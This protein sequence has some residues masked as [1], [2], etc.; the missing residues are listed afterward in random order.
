VRGGRDLLNNAALSTRFLAA[1]L[2]CLIRVSSV[3]PFC[4][5]LVSWA[6][7]SL[8][9]CVCVCVCVCA[10]VCVFVLGRTLRAQ[11]P[12]ALQCQAFEPL[13]Q[14]LCKAL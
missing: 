11:P 2:S 10:C 7:E 6:C 12:D 4:V 14:G 8:C 13:Y 1:Q 5:W 9:V 3:F